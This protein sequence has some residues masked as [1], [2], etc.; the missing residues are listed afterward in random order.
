MRMLHKNKK[1]KIKNFDIWMKI[2]KCK[3]QINKLFNKQYP[4]RDTIKK[5]IVYKYIKPQVV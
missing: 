5:Q 2:L 1:L 3:V 4:Q